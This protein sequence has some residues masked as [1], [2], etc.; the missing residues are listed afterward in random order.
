MIMTVLAPGDLND[1]KY[2]DELYPGYIKSLKDIYIRY[3]LFDI[4]RPL[5]DQLDSEEA[6][7]IRS[8]ER[9]LEI[10]K[11]LCKDKFIT[12][13]NLNEFKAMAENQ[14]RLVH[15]QKKK[16]TDNIELSGN[17]SGRVV[18]QYQIEEILAITQ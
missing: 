7:C 11:R 9:L 13:M 8:I 1:L 18:P 16:F 2:P 12:E 15:D 14:L 17:F 10:I 5:M 3:D 6:F 4:T